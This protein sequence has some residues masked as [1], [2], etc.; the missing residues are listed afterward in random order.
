MAQNQGGK[1]L[2]PVSPRGLL[3]AQKHTLKTTGNAGNVVNAGHGNQM[4]TFAAQQQV[5]Q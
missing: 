2:Q 3:S 1:T 4:L 5:L